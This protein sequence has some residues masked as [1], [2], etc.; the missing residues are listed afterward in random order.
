M[1]SK[2]RMVVDPAQ[3]K[4]VGAFLLLIFIVFCGFYYI[5]SEPKSIE[6]T[7]NNYELATFLRQRAGELH[8]YELKCLQLADQ[9]EE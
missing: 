2:N 9:L 4:F 5:K 6:R 1:V 3:G 7:L 8:Q